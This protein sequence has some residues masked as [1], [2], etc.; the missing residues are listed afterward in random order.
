MVVV[1]LIVE[2]AVPLVANISLLNVVVTREL[3]LQEMSS[4]ELNK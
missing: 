4:T 3:V 1:V 2:I